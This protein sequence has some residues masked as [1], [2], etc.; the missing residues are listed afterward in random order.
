MSSNTFDTGFTPLLRPPL[1]AH[2]PLTQQ[3]ILLLTDNRRPPGVACLHSLHISK[4]CWRTQHWV[5]GRK[6]LMASFS[7]TVPILSPEPVSIS[8]SIF[9]SFTSQLVSPRHI[10]LLQSLLVSLW[11]LLVSRDGM[12]CFFPILSFLIVPHILDKR[13]YHLHDA[14]S[15]PHDPITPHFRFTV[16]ALS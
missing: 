16:S 8:R 9:T 4:R 5:L 10:L 12:G 11:M 1:L 6:K 14:F 2:C 15:G 13:S 7:R 3:I